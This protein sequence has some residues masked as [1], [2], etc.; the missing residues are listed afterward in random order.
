MQNIIISFLSSV[1]SKLK[2]IPIKIEKMCEIM[3]DIF[4][5]VKR[6]FT[7]DMSNHYKFTPKMIE[8]W[9]LG[10]THY[11]PDNFTYGFFYEL[12]RIFGDRL[13]NVEHDMIFTDILRQ[14]SKYFSI[15]F[16]PN[17]NFF[18]QTSAK[19]SQLQMIDASNW[20]E[21]IEKNLP[22]CNSESAII[23]IPVTNELMKSVSSIIR[24]LSRPGKNICLA[25]KLGSGRFESTIIAC[26]ILN[27]KIF[28]P[29]ITRNYSMNDFSNDLKLAM[30]TCGLENEIAI[31]YIDQV[32]INFFPEILKSC[33]AILEDSFMNENLFGDDLE[34]IAN[35]LKG[36]AQ[37]EGYQESLVSF[38]L[39]REYY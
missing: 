27:I 12:S 39:N 31:L 34:T 38:F 33:E 2:N 35:S 18:I 11:P 17:E 22:I 3:L 16:E 15:K 25:G 20:S 24:A 37:L 8:D 26:T 5:E 23:D 21:M 6:N 9:I 10:L 30:Q 19:S 7:P 36:A 14:N 32:W 4:N 28:Y 1:F 29:Q 13:M